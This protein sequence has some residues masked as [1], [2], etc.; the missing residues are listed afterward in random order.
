MAT[1]ISSLL[2]G[3]ILLAAPLFPTKDMIY[4]R[5]RVSLGSRSGL[6]LGDQEVRGPGSGTHLGS[7]NAVNEIP[8]PVCT[9][10]QGRRHW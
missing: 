8:G 6:R 5:P 10:H 7:W 9:W 2:R 1:R 3:G 4:P